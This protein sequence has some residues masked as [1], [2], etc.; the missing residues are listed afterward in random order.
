MSRVVEILYPIHLAPE[1]D[2]LAK[3][4]LELGLEAAFDRLA[5]KVGVGETQEVARDKRATQCQGV[6][7]RKAISHD[8]FYTRH[9]TADARCATKQAATRYR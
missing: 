4:H 8:G 5:D 9:T 2:A 7:A 3:Q 1:E 6:A